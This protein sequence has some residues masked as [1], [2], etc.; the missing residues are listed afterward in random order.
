M[1]KNSADFYIW[2]AEWYL[3]HYLNTDLKTRL[4]VLYVPPNEAW[5]KG[6]YENKQCADC[7]TVNQYSLDYSKSEWE[8][9][10][11]SGRVERLTD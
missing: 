2:W 11:K 1:Y 3:R 4:S 9:G 8:R 10:D 5:R 7:T 6:Y